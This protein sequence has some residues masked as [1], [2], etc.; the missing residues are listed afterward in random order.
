MLEGFLSQLISE[1]QS[2]RFDVSESCESLR[3]SLIFLAEV[4]SSRQIAI[5]NNGVGRMLFR[6]DLNKSKDCLSSMETTAPSR[7]H[8]LIIQEMFALRH[9]ASKLSTIDEQF[10]SPAT[11]ASNLTLRRGST[12]AK[13]SQTSS[14]QLEQTKAKRKC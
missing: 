6:N 10:P 11:T 8:V 12:A 9:G 2:E 3:K 4:T 1:I 7:A 14:R 13:Y 5:D